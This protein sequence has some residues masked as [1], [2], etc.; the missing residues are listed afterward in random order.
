MRHLRQDT[1]LSPPSPRALGRKVSP[2]WTVP[3]CA[4]HHRA[5]HDAGDEQRWW[6]EQGHDPFGEAEKLWRQS[7]GKAA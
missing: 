5:L 1:K 7:H 3:L 2:K 4:I 6:K